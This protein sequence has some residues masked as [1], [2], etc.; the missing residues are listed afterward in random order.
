LLFNINRVLISSSLC[1]FFYRM[2]LSGLVQWVA[3]V[4]CRS[5]CSPLVEWTN[6]KLFR[7]DILFFRRII[8]I[9]V[10]YFVEYWARTGSGAV[11]G[12]HSC[13]DFQGI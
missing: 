4:K 8:C 3:V 11:M 13:V 2:C 9:L 5:L 1:L 12:R 10:G 7:Y 6:W